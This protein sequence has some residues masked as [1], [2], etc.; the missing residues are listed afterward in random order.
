MEISFAGFGGQG[1]LTSGLVTAYIAMK[2]G[3]EVM[4][5]PSYGGQ[6]RGGKSFSMVKFEKEPIRNPLMS[7]L[8]ALVAMNGPSLDYAAD[9]KP[10][11]ILI[12]NSDVVGE[13]AQVQAPGATIIRIP[14]D[15]LARQAQS[16]KGANLVA[17]GT[18]I[19]EIG[20][21]SLEEAIDIMNEFF[22]N[23]GKGK[24]NEANDRAFQAGYE[25]IG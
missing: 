15:T 6:M 12:I 2:K 4:W 10:G 23:K 5:S 9:L 16:S 1:V 13:D 7:K 24:F 25:Y 22:T 19:R 21:C 18:L 17:V 8:D 20:L 11:G 3:Y 14:V